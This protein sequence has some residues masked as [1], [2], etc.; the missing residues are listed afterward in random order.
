M[1][2]EEAAP[3]LL[4]TSESALQPGSGRFNRRLKREHSLRFRLALKNLVA[5]GHIELVEGGPAK[6]GVGQRASL[7]L[8]DDGIDPSCLVAHLQTHLTRN[9]EKSL[10]ID[11][12]S[13][14]TALR[15]GVQQVQMKVGLLVGQR[16]IRLNL[17]RVN[18]LSRAV[19]N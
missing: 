10:T 7:R 13:I 6:D 19:G 2:F 11:G 9:I 8:R 12:H 14:R 1:T 3:T 16:S 4:N 15:S 18:H 17:K 5:V